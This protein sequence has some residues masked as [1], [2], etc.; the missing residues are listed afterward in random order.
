MIRP[1]LATLLLC[2]AAAPALAATQGSYIS[3]HHEQRH[4]SRASGISFT[5]Y[6]RGLALGISANKITSNRVQALQEQGTLYPVYAFAKVALNTRIAPY[7]EFGVDLGDYLLHEIGN[8]TS[9]SQGSSAS[10]KPDNID[11]YGA[12]GIKTSMRRA[13]IDFALYIKSYA[14]YLNQ[15][16]INANGELRSE[17]TIITMSG[18][19]IIFNF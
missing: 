11:A 9:S 4:D 1:W 5:A 8:D 3:L 15:P 18:A 6:N 12:I 7:V 19:N 10:S 14:L 2:T 16:H 13:P 17:G